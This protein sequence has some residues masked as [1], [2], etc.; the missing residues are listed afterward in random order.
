MASN[1]RVSELETSLAENETTLRS[2]LSSKSWR[3]T[4]PL[5]GILSALKK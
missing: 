4:A 5:R 1:S 3:L 2:V